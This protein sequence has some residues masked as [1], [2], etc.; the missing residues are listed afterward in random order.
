MKMGLRI[1]CMSCMLLMGCFLGGR[2]MVKESRTVKSVKHD[3]ED[4]APTE[5]LMR[6]H[7]ILRR[8]LLIYDNFTHRIRKQQV[9]NVPALRQAVLLVDSFIHNYHEKL[10]EDYIFPVFEKHKKQ[11]HLVKTLRTQHDKG[12][13]ITARLL[14]ITDPKKNRTTAQMHA[15]YHEIK[16]LLKDFMIMYRP[17]A[18]RE[19]TVL[20]PGLRA[21]MSADAFDQLGDYFED[22][23]RKLFGKQGFEGIVKQVARIE[24][25][26]D[27]YE[28]EQFTPER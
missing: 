24:Q 19:D 4:V 22:S 3:I 14:E 5:D 15:M 6:E 8:L 26:L 23:E 9:I 17:H 21:L 7:G 27:L 1:G 18:A 2:P 10:E 25:E 28:L 11:L 16:N 20:F 13:L 12:R